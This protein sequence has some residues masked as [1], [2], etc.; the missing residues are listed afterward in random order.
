VVASASTPHA[1]TPLTDAVTNSQ[2]VD[3]EDSARR[4]KALAERL[5]GVASDLRSLLVESRKWQAE[6]EYGDPLGPESWTP[7]YADYMKRLDAVIAGM[8]AKSETSTIQQNAAAERPVDDRGRPEPDGTS[9]TMVVTSRGSPDG[10]A[11]H[12]DADLESP[13]PRGRRREDRGGPGRSYSERCSAAAPSNG[14][15]STSDKHAEMLPETVEQALQHMRFGCPFKRD[16][17]GEYDVTYFERRMLKGADVLERELSA[18]QDHPI[19]R[20][21]VGPDGVVPTGTVQALELWKAEADRLHAE[22]AGEKRLNAGLIEGVAK[23]KAEIERLRSAPSAEREH[24][25]WCRYVH[26]DGDPTRIVCCNSD[27]QGAFKVYRS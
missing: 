12:P 7:E 4:Y 25:A 5:E 18:L 11:V 24:V 16:G 13:L 3:W 1:A 22:L 20:L 14:E 6:G 23:H 15:D 9:G 8:P 10:G 27:D 17:I 19:A 2:W 21:Q 26:I